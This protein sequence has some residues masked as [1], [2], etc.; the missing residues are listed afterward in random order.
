M[1]K[2]AKKEKEPALEELLQVF[3]D[4]KQTPEQKEFVEKQVFK[5]LRKELNYGCNSCYQDAIIELVK[6]QREQP[7]LYE[8][9]QIDPLF[10]L[11]RG[12][13]VS[14][15]FGSSEFLVYQNCTDELALK[16]LAKNPENIEEF[17]VY[18]ENWKELISIEKPP[19]EE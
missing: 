11:K 13:L 19:V 6:M 3:R 14:Y 12:V 15:E 5:V 18:P 4:G 17:D 1:G 9:R 16:F 8:A 10:V 7:D 2:K